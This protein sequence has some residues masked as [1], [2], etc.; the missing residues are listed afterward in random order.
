MTP[1]DDG[2]GR[3]VGV[4][5]STQYLP[6]LE[7]LRGLAALMVLA[8]HYDAM[9]LR[10]ASPRAGE[11]CTPFYAFVRGGHSGVNLFFVL[12]AFLLSLPFLASGSGGPPVSLRRYARRRALR[13]LPLYY[14]M[15][16]IGAVA[17]ASALADL[18]RGLPYLLFLNGFDLAAPIKPYSNVWWSLATEAQFY[19]FLPLVP[20]ALR[21]RRGR[22][23]GVAALI[24]YGVAWILYERRAILT[25]STFSGS[26]TLSLSLFARG[27]IFL[28]G[29]GAA[30][31]YRRYGTDWRRWAAMQPWLRSGGG[32][33][34]L[35]AVLAA[36]AYYLRW[37]TF[38]G[39]GRYHA[40]PDHAWQALGGVLWGALVLL[41]LV[42]PLH[43]KPLLHNRIWTSLG[44]LSYSLY[45]LHVPVL[46]GLNGG[47]QSLGIGR[48]AG[49]WRAAVV[50]AVATV[51]VVSLSAATYR[52]IERP[53]LQRKEALRE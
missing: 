15:V 44:V 27:P 20:L 33:L 10:F 21:S 48:W 9:L 28:C 36:L 52:W 46:S 4:A 43:L 53:F 18:W 41:L 11:W 37:L 50:G 17:T 24:G 40:P 30:A 34:L 35:V 1:R 13:I 8:F 14:V 38:I 47:L 16:V 32:D 42:A 12:S 22:F 3:P 25:P 5:L 29:I 31:L 7:S 26:M 2:D 19:L 39:P 6:E 51:V 23:V 49:P 45:V